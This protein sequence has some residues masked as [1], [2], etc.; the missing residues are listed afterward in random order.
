MGKDYD[1]DEK[2]KIMSVSQKLNLALLF[3]QSKHPTSLE[4]VKCAFKRPRESDDTSTSTGKKVRDQSASLFTP[5]ELST[6]T[7]C[8]VS[9]ARV[10]SLV[11]NYIVNCM[12]PLSTV[13]ADPFIELVTGLQPK[14]TV[15]TR[16]TLNGTFIFKSVSSG[17]IAIRLA[18]RSTLA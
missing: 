8:S 12:R 10:D 11:M 9:Q 4:K 2:L 3:V 18:D 15:M 16:K 17:S 13:E 1:E 6:G 5:V 7:L 14:K